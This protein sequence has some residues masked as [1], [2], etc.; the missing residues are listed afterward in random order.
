M[1]RA[2]L[3]VLGWY[4]QYRALRPPACRFD[5]TCS[6]YVMSAVEVHGVVKGLYLGTRRVMRCHP[7]GGTG[8][9]PV[10]AAKRLATPDRSFTR[11][12]RT[13]EIGHRLV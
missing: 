1:K 10:P 5:P 13:D 2:V 7:L 3:S 12:T 9:D 6:G 4:Q 11:E 8:Y